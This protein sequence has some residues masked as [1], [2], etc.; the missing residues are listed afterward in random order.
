MNSNAEKSLPANKL[1][2]QSKPAPEILTELNGLWESDLTPDKGSA[3]ISG[4]DQQYDDWNAAWNEGEPV[5]I[6]SFEDEDGN[7]IWN[8]NPEPAASPM[9]FAAEIAEPRPPA[10]KHPQGAACRFCGRIIRPGNAL[11]GN[12]GAPAR[13]RRLFHDL[14]EN[15]KG[16]KHNPNLVSC[17]VCRQFV[18][19]R[20]RFCPHC[21]ELLLKPVYPGDAI[22]DDHDPANPIKAKNLFKYILLLGFVIILA[23]FIMSYTKY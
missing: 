4:R 11:C 20:A 3:E 10:A 8:D 2:A 9:P 15:Y 17:G 23:I 16:G 19:R 14:G 12:C 5:P 7:P 18:Y 22:A 1:Y 21:G 13:P 6:I